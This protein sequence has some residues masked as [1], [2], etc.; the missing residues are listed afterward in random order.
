MA[1]VFQEMFDAVL[2]LHAPI[3]KRKRKSEYAPWLNGG[4]RYLMLRKDKAKKDARRNPKLWPLYKKL[5]NEVTEAIRTALQDHCSGL[6]EQNKNMTVRKRK[7]FVA[8]I[9]RTA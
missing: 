6:I 7:A 2:S 9:L 4:I 5:K 3:R 1:S 8:S